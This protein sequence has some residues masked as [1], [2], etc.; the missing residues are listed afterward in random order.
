MKTIKLLLAIALL[1]GTIVSTPACGKYEE[2]PGI[3]L[4][5]KKQ[6]L[7]R[8]W[9][10]K[11]YVSSSGTTIADNDD[12][13]ITFEKDGTGKITIGSIVFNGTWEFTSNKEKITSVYSNTASEVTILRLTNKEL[14]TKDSD[15]DITK[16]EAK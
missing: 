9:D 7:C 2:G 1:G 5:T 16:F 13:Y 14:W 15:G 12:D 4:L 3:S 6:R 11:E 8:S 10:A